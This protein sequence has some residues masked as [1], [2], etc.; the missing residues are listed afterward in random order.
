MPMFQQPRLS[1]PACCLLTTVLPTR[2]PQW[3]ELAAGARQL[4][5]DKSTTRKKDERKKAREDEKTEKRRLK[6]EGPH[7]SATS[8]NCSCKTAAGIR[9]AAE[10]ADGEEEEKAGEQSG[11]SGPALEEFAQS[12][13][14]R[15]PLFVEQCVRF[16][17]QEGLDSEGLYRVPGNRAHVEL[18]LQRLDEGADLVAELG[19]SELPVNAVATALKDFFSKRLPPLLSHAHMAR[20]T[21]IAGQ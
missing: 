11:R 6:E 21:E 12:D 18:L 17:E 15:T 8:D 16:I 4:L 5:K 1:C 13:A 14:V 3:G 7:R 19:S 9:G 2:A 20:L 10:A